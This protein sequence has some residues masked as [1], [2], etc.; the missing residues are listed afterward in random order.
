MRALVAVS[1]GF[2]LLST[3]AAAAPGSHLDIRYREGRLTIHAQSTPANEVFAAI[4]EETSVRFVVDSEIRSALITI[5]IDDM[6]L[7]R[8]I[9]KVVR[10]VRP[11]AAMF[12]HGDANG[13]TRLEQVALFGP[14]KAPE[15]GQAAVLEAESEPITAA[16]MPT[17]DVMQSLIEAGVPEEAAQGVIDLNAEMEKLRATP[18]SGSD[19][20]T[21][22]DQLQTLVDRGVSMERAMQ[23]LLFE[24]RRRETLKERPV[25]GLSVD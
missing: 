25:R 15:G 8:G 20:P 2:I 18:V 12:H 13:E 7:E 5:D 9:R 17:P 19:R 3:V 14:G 24:E 16:S 4:T 22:R 21:P 11:A 1:S 23:M 6:E 10:A